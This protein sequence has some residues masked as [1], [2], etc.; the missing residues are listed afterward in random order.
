MTGEVTQTLLVGAVLC[1]VVSVQISSPSDET[2]QDDASLVAVS[3]SGIR[4]HSLLY[5]S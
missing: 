2:E 3:V 4:G 5:T 1:L